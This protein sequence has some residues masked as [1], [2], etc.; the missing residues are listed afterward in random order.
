MNKAISKRGLDS[1]TVH[2]DRTDAEVVCAQLREA[3][4]ICWSIPDR[5]NP[6]LVMVNTCTNEQFRKIYNNTF[7]TG[8]E[9]AS[10]R[11]AN[12]RF[13]RSSPW[14]KRFENSGLEMRRD[15]TTHSCRKALQALLGFS[16]FSGEFRWIVE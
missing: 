8:L 6:Y 11:D 2:Q 3:C 12:E 1:R 5:A 14:A 16:P 9:R 15:E 13:S 4:L 10:E 7:I